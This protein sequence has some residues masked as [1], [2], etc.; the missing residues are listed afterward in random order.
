[1]QIAPPR[2]GVGGHTHDTTPPTGRHNRSGNPKDADEMARA[3]DKSH[4]FFI[5]HDVSTIWKL[6]KSAGESAKY[7]NADDY[8]W[9]YIGTPGRLMMTGWPTPSSKQ[10]QRS[11]NYPTGAY[12]ITP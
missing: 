6:I 5:P 8:Q 2:G 12:V 3:G 1:M 4:T 11:R 9:Q 10:I 7:F